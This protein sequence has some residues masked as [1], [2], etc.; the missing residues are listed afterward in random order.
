[1]AVHIRTL[2]VINCYGCYNNKRFLV[3]PPFCTWGRFCLP[4]YPLGSV[5]WAMGD[6]LL[7][8]NNIFTVIVLS[9]SMIQHEMGNTCLLLSSNLVSSSYKVSMHSYMYKYCFNI[10]RR[11]VLLLLPP[12]CTPT[13]YLH[14]ETQYYDI[15]V[16]IISMM[17]AVEA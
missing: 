13:S 11:A 15:H 6:H 4:S 17:A 12:T 7:L 1:M 10:A 5:L 2:V 16:H 14:L 8:K 9:S 3:L